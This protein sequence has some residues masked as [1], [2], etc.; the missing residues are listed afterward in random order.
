MASDN[1][2]AALTVNS[3]PMTASRDEPVVPQG[4]AEQR[5][6]MLGWERFVAG[7]SLAQTPLDGVLL[8]SWQRSR[9]S[10]VS[11]LGRLAPLAA[12]GDTLERLRLRHGD[13]IQ[14]SKG[15][16]ESTA[17]AL[18]SSQSIILLTDP[19]GIVLD[20]GGDMRTLDMGRA[21]NLMQGGQWREDL[22]GTNGIGLA[23]STG[24]PSLVHAA[25]HFCEGI[26]R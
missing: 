24:R 21:V 23:L 18:F 20:A 5:N 25:Q 13:L 2:A 14:A 11:P 8:S 12:D 4:V 10:G 22:I 19:D 1:S 3:P 7:E 6:T 17:E 26:K 9:S 16:F 15:F